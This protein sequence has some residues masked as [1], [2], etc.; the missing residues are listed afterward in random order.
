MKPNTPEWLAWMKTVEPRMAAL[1]SAMIEAAGRPDVCSICGDNPSAD[2]QLV[3]DPRF[4]LRLCDDCRR[5]RG[6]Q[7]G[8]EF[9]PLP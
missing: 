3:S 1:T 7:Y 2:Y 5:G 9:T 4:T 6:A 8:E